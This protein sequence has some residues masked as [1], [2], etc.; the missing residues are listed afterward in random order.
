MMTATLP[1]CDAMP[2]LGLGTWGLRGAHSTRVVRLA[3][4]VGY[5]IDTAEFYGNHMQIGKA[6]AQA[7]IPRSEFFI[8]TKK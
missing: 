6:L 8:T 5:R 1:S 7:D 4:D 3:V 2:L